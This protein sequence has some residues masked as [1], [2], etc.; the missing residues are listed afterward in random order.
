MFSFLFKHNLSKIELL[1]LVFIWGISS[2]GRAPALHAGG[3][4]FDPAILHHSYWDTKSL[5]QVL[6]TNYYVYKW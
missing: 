2:A 5:K 6:L 4:R 1:S 3:Q